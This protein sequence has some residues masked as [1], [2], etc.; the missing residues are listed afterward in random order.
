MF[1][2]VDGLLNARRLEVE[3][4][5]AST[6]KQG[7]GMPGGTVSYT[8]KHMVHSVSHFL[9]PAKLIQRED[10]AN[11]NFDIP[12]ERCQVCNHSPERLRR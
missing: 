7:S 4:K 12:R 1:G 6:T 5:D 2:K 9:W 3:I 10:A 8:G 11:F